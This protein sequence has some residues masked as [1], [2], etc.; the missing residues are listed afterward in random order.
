MFESRVLWAL[1]LW[2]SLPLAASPCSE[3]YHGPNLWTI[4]DCAI[5]VFTFKPVHPIMKTI[6]PGAGFGLGASAG[7]S[8]SDA[9]VKSATTRFFDLKGTFAKSINGSVFAEGISTLRLHQHSANGGTTGGVTTF[10]LYGRRVEMA[11]MD[12][13]SIGNTSSRAGLAVFKER[14]WTVGADLFRPI[15][16]FVGVGGAFEGLGVR[17][18][19]V[20]GSSAPSVV[21]RYAEAAAPGVLRQPNMLHYEAFAAVSAP[22]DPPLF[23]DYKL[24]YH[25]YQDLDYNAYNFRQFEADLLNTIPLRIRTKTPMS[26]KGLLAWLCPP[27]GARKECQYGTLSLNG[28][29]TIS[30]TGT[31]Q[32]I[33][34]YLQP[35]LGGAEIRDIDTLRG[36]ADYRFRAPD[37][38]MLQVQYEHPITLKIKG[39]KRDPLGFLA[40]YDV[41]HVAES[42]SELG[43]THLRHD[44][45]IGLSARAQ[46]RVYF[47]VYIAF[48]G[49]EGSRLATKLPSLF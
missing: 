27:R 39:E 31:G 11:E 15:N 23:I 25:Q 44:F 32:R 14:L 6:V 33:P 40:F 36:F 4:E 47:R 5:S 22:A 2:C 38:V 41:G 9:S 26:G 48:G 7:T 3:A 34:F 28:L 12:F 30:G 16:Q 29:L 45:G 10:H 35:T 21:G 17:V 13:Y 43:F 37:R 46:N 24:S 42:A 49:G 1:G 19:G 18:L 20:S 8:G